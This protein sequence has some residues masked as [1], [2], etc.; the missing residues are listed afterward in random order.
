MYLF[1]ETITQMCKHTLNPRLLLFVTVKDQ[2]QPKY[3]SDK[4]LTKYNVAL[5]K[6]GDYIVVTNNEVNTSHNS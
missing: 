4:G 6:H 2:K 5:S 1:C 3:V